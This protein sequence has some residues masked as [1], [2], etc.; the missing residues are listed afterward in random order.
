MVLKASHRSV[1]SE[2][3]DHIQQ[4]G[5]RMLYAGVAT[6]P[7]YETRHVRPK[8]DTVNDY[9][10]IMELGCEQTRCIAFLGQTNCSILFIKFIYIVELFPDDFSSAFVS[11][12]VL[13]IADGVVHTDATDIS[14][15]RDHAFP[16]RRGELDTVRDD[17]RSGNTR[18]VF[19]AVQRELPELRRLHERVRH[20]DPQLQTYR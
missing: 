8:I 20:T 13:H 12:N 9:Q 3:L 19:V 6:V 11:V 7:K 1:S 10:D 14:D 5:Y 17:A 18:G 2:F 15:P 16:V 4:T